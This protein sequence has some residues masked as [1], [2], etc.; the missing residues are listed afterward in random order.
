MQCFYMMVGLP[1]S[2]KSWYAENKLPDAVIHSSD[3]IREELLIDISD[4]NHQEL[5][6][7]TLHDRVLSDLRAGKDVVYDATN[8]SYKR[9][10][11]FL[12]RVTAVNPQIKKVCVFMATPY[13]LCVERNANRERSVPENVID[14]MYRG[15][16]I[17]M[18]A[19][20]WDEI[21]VEGVEPFIGG[22]SLLL[23]HLAALEHDNPHHEFT[24][25]QHMLTAYEYFDKQY[26]QWVNDISLGRAVAIHDIGKEY[27]KVFCNAK[28]EPTDIAHFYQHE[29]VGAYESFAHTTDLTLHERLKVALLIR[30]HMA[31]FAVEKS[32]N[33]NKTERK[34]KGLLGED[35]WNQVM[36]LNDCDRHAH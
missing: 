7:Q 11:G 35:I 16:D 15:F 29:R 4:Q 34:F 3:T 2:G 21:W 9:R 30:W 6:F 28:G 25:G 18:E 5:V 1:G 12:H 13:I 36:V 26:P 10:M 24:V 32:D 23:S 27:T 14:R 22:I 31:P 33:P 19:E 8:V 17:P 20:G